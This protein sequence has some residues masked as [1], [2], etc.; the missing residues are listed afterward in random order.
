VTGARRASEEGA[1]RAA[2]GEAATPVAARGPEALR[3]G[4]GPDLRV[5]VA[6]IACANPVWAA[7][8]CCGYGRELAALFPLAQLGA[9]CVKGTS[10][11]PWPGNPG[12]RVVETAAG[13][14]NAIGLQNPGVDH[15]LRVDLPWLAEQGVPVVV[16]VVGRT[17]DEYAAVVRRLAEAPP[18][19]VAG[20]EVNISCPNVRQGG[21]QFGADP[22]AAAEV[23]AAVRAATRLPLLVKLSPNVSDVCAFAAAVERAGADAI[24][25]INTLLGMRLDP[26]RRRPVLA[27]TTGG[28]S[29]PAVK[30]VA[31]RMVWEVAGA[32]AV[33]VVGIGGIASG[34]DALEFLLAGACAVQVGTSIFADPWA[35]VRVRDELAAWMEREGVRTVGELVGAARPRVTG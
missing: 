25:L 23:T 3:P 1:P 8:G 16:N 20:V 21:L 10:L 7:S 30:P 5:C 12:P 19:A 4:T 13:M 33:P 26:V 18:G 22:V 14:L 29:G 35:P 11:E 6:G 17:V 2:H 24:S 34:A 28:L 9:I 15:L 31:L 27:N 32:V